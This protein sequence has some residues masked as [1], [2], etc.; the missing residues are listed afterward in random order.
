MVSIL[1]LCPSQGEARMILTISAA[2]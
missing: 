2:A 1:G